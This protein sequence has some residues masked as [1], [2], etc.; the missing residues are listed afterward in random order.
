MPDIPSLVKDSVSLIGRVLANYKSPAMM[1]SFGKDS[2]V[3]LHIL[4][5]HG[6]KPKIVFY[7]DP[8]WPQKYQFADW[9]INAWGLEVYDYPPSEITMWEGKEIMAFTNHYQVG[10]SSN[11]II[12]LPKNIL[13]PEDGRK[14]I[15]GLDLLNRPKGSF[16]FPW[17]VMFVGHKSSDVDQIAGSVKLH[18][19]I[20]KNAPGVPDFAFPLR[21]WTDNDIWEYTEANSIP[22]QWDRYD[23][24]TRK[25][26]D[27]KWTNSDYANVCIRCIDRRSKEKSVYCPKLQCQVSNISD[28]IPYQDVAMDYFGD[29]NDKA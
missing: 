29:D 3:L 18:V 28:Q 14:W 4:V 1:C 16:A 12:K 20:K 17:D 19:D 23:R 8:W 9:V 6:F 13:N 5:S 2:M 15:C 10:Y 7:R 11:A 25:E 26:W 24:A 21:N 22:Q 27:D